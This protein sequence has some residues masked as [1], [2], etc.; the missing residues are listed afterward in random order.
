M[1]KK[2]SGRAAGGAKKPAG[3][4]R[5][6]AVSRKGAKRRRPVPKKPP[7][8]MAMAVEGGGGGK[9]LKL[10]LSPVPVTAYN[11][12]VDGDPVSFAGGKASRPIAPGNH[13]LSWVIVHTPGV[14]VTIG[15]TAPPEAVWSESR[16][17]P[18]SGRWDGLHQFYVYA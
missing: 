12:N 1:V 16:E 15:I 10:T 5:K 17:M 9:E 14:V 13:V 2:Q 8:G 4:K 18:P 6:A 7:V 3:V 11:V